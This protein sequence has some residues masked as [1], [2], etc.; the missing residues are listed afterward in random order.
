MA[1]D[2][3]SS[4]DSEFLDL[5]GGRKENILD[6]PFYTLDSFDLP[7]CHCIRG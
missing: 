1:G 4:I 2:L 3:S 5:A 6:A 7:D